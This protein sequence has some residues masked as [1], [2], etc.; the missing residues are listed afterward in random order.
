MRKACDECGA[1]ISVRRLEVREGTGRSSKQYVYCVDCGLVWLERRRLEN[2][3]AKQYLQT[4]QGEI[5]LPKKEQ[6]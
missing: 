5:R 3:R 2:E 6:E 4:G 1:E